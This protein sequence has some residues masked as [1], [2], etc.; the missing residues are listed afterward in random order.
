VTSGAQVMSRSQTTSRVQVAS[1]KEEA[2]RLHGWGRRWHQGCSIG[3]EAAP[4]KNALHTSAARSFGN[5]WVVVT[6]NSQVVELEVMVMLTQLL[7]RPST[8]L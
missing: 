8:S 7:R 2:S 6:A 5:T 4:R 3:E 1:M